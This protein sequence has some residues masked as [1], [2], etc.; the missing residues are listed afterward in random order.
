[1]AQHQKRV[2]HMQRRRDQGLT[3]AELGKEYGMSRQHAGRLLKQRAK[4]NDY[5]EEC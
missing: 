1:M 3:H 2:D 4:N 5:D